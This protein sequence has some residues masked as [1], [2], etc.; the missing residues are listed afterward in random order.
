[1]AS[2]EHTLGAGGGIYPENDVTVWARAEVPTL[3]PVKFQHPYKDLMQVL[4]ERSSLMQ[5]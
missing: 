1:M 2:E 4:S 3:G 5:N